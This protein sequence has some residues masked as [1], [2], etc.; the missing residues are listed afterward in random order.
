MPFK[1]SPISTN[2]PMISTTGTQLSFRGLT[3]APT[4]KKTVLDNISGSFHS[5]RLTAIIGPS[6]SGK[7]SLLNAL[8]GFGPKSLQGS[9]LVNNEELGQQNYRKLVAYNT[10]EATLLP[11]LTVEETL[12]YAV[13]LRTRSTAAEKRKIVDEIIS[14]L[15]LQKSAHSQARVLSGGG[16]KRLSIGQDLISNPKILLFD[17][18]TSGLDS[19]SSYQI[20]SHLKELT[21]Q[22]R[23]VISVIHQPSSDLLELYDDLYVVY[24]GRCMYRGSLQDLIPW[25]ESAGIVCPQYYNRADFVIKLTSENNPHRSKVLE[26]IN[27]MQSENLQEQPSALSTKAN[28]SGRQYPTSWFHQ[29]VTL[30]R[31]TVL[32]TVRNNALFV[33]RFAGLIAFGLTLGFIFHDIGD[34]AAKTISNTS[35]LALTL[36]SLTFVNAAAQIISFPTEAAV[37]IREYRANCYSVAAYFFSKLSA[38]FFPLMIGNSALFGITYFLTGQPTEMERILKSWL[39]QLLSGWFG[40][41]LG[42][43]SGCLFSLQVATF[44]V[45]SALLAMLLFSGFFIHF[46]ELNVVLRPLIYVSPFSYG[47]K[48]ILDAVYGF[49]RTE[50]TCHVES[51]CVYRTGEQVLHMLDMQGIEYWNEVAGLCTCV[52]VLLVGFFVCLLFKIK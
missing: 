34:D 27:Q 1:I 11:N 41:L 7:S 18:P 45:P 33:L 10:Q 26:L 40:Q 29:F 5:G 4:P 35:N 14:V 24:D 17:E 8:S 30:T 37:F 13:E 22:D 28:L 44:F 42:I 9:I 36:S 51:D 2:I 6:G 49:N 39:I 48:G 47:F 25:Y 32:G 43:I 23:C 3:F 19:E 52:I 38:D 15:A 16:Q 21:K 46:S 31:R 50:L 12:E 20:M